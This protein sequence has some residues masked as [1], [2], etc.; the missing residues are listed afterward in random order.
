VDPIIKQIRGDLAASS[1]EAT[2]KGA[3]RFF[4][5][6][7]RCYGVKSAIVGK[8]AKQYWRDVKKRDKQEIF[9]LCEEL[10]SSGYMEDAFI[11]SNWMDSMSDKLT[12]LDLPV[13]RSWISS[14]ITNWAMCDGLCNHAVGNLVD[15]Y[16][17][18]VSELLSWTTSDNRWMRR[19]AAV[20]L[21]IPAK[22][23]KFLEESIAIADLLLT[24]EDD[25]VR[26]GYGWLLKEAS[27]KH[28]QVIFEYVMKNKQKMPR[29][30][31]RYA[32]ELMPPDLRKLAMQKD[33]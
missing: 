25:M 10:Y 1:D 24:D 29:T 26:K 27:R 33:W 12:P 2:Q 15:S 17:E 19:A 6:E 28:Q 8:I 3:V 23:G 20:T 11:V 32:I 7:I 18:C 21:I 22:Y 16:P 31:L 30:S 13:I 5:E 14:Y 4:R 9:V